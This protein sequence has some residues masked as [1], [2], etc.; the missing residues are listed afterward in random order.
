MRRD[1]QARSLLGELLSNA[2]LVDA[3]AR[4]RVVSALIGADGSGD[5]ERWA[6]A[7]A[8]NATDRARRLLVVATVMNRAV[9]AAGRG[10]FYR[11]IGNGPDPC[12]DLF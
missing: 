9:Q 6:R 2:S 11:Q 7:P 10:P 12:L 5:A 4:L 1:E 8:G 3:D